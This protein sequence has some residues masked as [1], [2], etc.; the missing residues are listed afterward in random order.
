MPKL[1]ERFLQTFVT[2]SENFKFRVYLKTILEAMLWK[3]CGKSERYILYSTFPFL[4]KTQ[5]PSNHEVQKE[6]LLDQNWS[7]LAQKLVS[8]IF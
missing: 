4:G 6:F 2:F 8:I 5:P 3:K 1:R 7:S